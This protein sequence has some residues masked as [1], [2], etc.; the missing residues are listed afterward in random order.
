MLAGTRVTCL[1]LGSAQPVTGPIDPVDPEALAPPEPMV[2]VDPLDPVDPV[3]LTQSQLGQLDQLGQVD[4]LGQLEHPVQV[5]QLGPLGPPIDRRCRRTRHVTCW[6]PRRLRLSQVFGECG[7][8]VNVHVNFLDSSGSFHCSLTTRFAVFLNAAEGN[9][10]KI[11]V[12]QRVCFCGNGF[13]PAICFGVVMH[14]FCK[15]L[16]RH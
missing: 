7:R 1:D 4:Q 12:W 15:K 5:G 11:Q 10:R 14:T 3:A 6:L 13:L 8:V 9:D 16:R 2:P